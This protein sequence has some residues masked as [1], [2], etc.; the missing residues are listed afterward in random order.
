MEIRE[1]TAKS[2]KGIRERE[3]MM[4]DAMQ[5]IRGQIDAI[6]ALNRSLLQ[7]V[8]GERTINGSFSLVKQSTE[9]RELTEKTMED[10]ADPM[11]EDDDIH[12][13]LFEMK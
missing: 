13:P 12:S 1:G 6:V 10:Y 7:R 4:S 5:T 2:I 11:E 8:M 9:E 3:K